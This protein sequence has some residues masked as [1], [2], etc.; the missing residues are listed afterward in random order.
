MACNRIHALGM[1][2]TGTQVQSL[3]VGSVRMLQAAV[4]DHVLDCDSEQGRTAGRDRI[5]SGVAVHSDIFALS[6]IREQD[7]PR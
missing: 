5:C 2:V 4:V 6:A 7:H 3:V 1:D